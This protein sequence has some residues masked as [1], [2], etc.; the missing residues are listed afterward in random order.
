M[1]LRAPIMRDL[2]R[3]GETALNHPIGSADGVRAMVAWF[4]KLFKRSAA[5][6][7]DGMAAVRN[8][9]QKAMRNRSVLTLEAP[10]GVV[11][12]TTV[13]RVS[14]SEIIVTQ[15]SV[16]GIIYP[17]AEGEWLK[18]SFIELSTHLTGRTK[19]LGRIK[20]PGMR[21]ATVYRMSLP[22]TL[23][24]DDRRGEPRNEINPSVAPEIRITGA[25]IKDVMIGTLADISTTGMRIHT[26]ACTDPIEITQELTVRFL[27][28][29]PAGQMD[30][31]VEVQRLEKDVGT[32]LNAICVSL[33]RRIPRL[34]TLL[35]MTTERE[36]MPLEQAQRKIA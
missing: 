25:R 1:G 35:R 31:V 17:L 6:Q 10:Q 8:A 11:A 22:E 32:G 26:S 24:F 33:R 4:S 28:P 5:P 7:A 34:E 9:L 16:G 30:E 21:G 29:E 14:S 13:L 20:A 18:L 23:R 19:C 12:R 2:R 36:P 3:P 27:M 15:P